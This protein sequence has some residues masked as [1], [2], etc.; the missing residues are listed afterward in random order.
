[1]CGILT[2]GAVGGRRIGVVTANTALA[3]LPNQYHD[4]ANVFDVAKA[5]VLPKHH[6]MEHKIKVEEGKEPP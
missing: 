1:M 5:G 6:L 4:Y 2:Q 3:V